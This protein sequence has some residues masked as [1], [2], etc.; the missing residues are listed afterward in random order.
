MINR[1]IKKRARLICCLLTKSNQFVLYQMLNTMPLGLECQNTLEKSKYIY[2]KALCIKIGSNKLAKIEAN[3]V[4]KAIVVH[5]Q[6]QG[7]SL[8]FRLSQTALNSISLTQIQ[9]DIIIGI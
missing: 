8:G 4:C 2:P 9:K 3:T 5:G 7:S 6:Y 1:Q